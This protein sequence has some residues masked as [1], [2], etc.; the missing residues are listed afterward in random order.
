MLLGS[1]PV[2]GTWHVSHRQES[3]AVYFNVPVYCVRF[4]LEKK[5]VHL[6]AETMDSNIGFNTGLMF[7]LSNAYHLVQVLQ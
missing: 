2:L 7:A 6:G 1:C 4:C 5:T 3:S